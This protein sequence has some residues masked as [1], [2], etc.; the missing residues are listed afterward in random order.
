MADK[1]GTLRDRRT[2]VT[3]ASGNY[4]ILAD[5]SDSLAY[6]R[7]GT[8][9]VVSGFNGEP[10]EYPRRR[11]AGRRRR[12]AARADRSRDAAFQATPL[13]AWCVQGSYEAHELL[14]L[15][16]RSL[17]RRCRRRVRAGKPLGGTRADRT[18]GEAPTI[19]A[20][21]GGR[22]RRS[23][24]L[25]DQRRIHGRP[26]PRRSPGNRRDQYAH[27]LP[28]GMPVPEEQVLA[29]LPTDRP[30]FEIPCATPSPADRRIGTLVA[31]RMGR[32]FDPADRD[33]Q[34]PRHG[35]R[36]AAG[37]ARPADPHRDAVRRPGGARAIRGRSRI[38]ERSGTRVFAF[39][40]D[41]LYEFM[42]GNASLRMGPF[43]EVN[44]PA[45][46]A[47]E[48]NMV[49]VCATTEVDLYGQCVSGTITDDWYSGSGGQLDFMRGVHAAPDGQ[50]FMLLH[51][52]LSDGSS[53]I[54]LS[55][56]PSSAVTTGPTW[57]TKS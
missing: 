42:D 17:V 36:G 41:I 57:S 46:I 18:P 4:K 34:R 28:A 3:S 12:P 15:S 40:T 11:R 35:L 24:L 38:A 30:M 13:D 43:D 56:S 31:E 23:P 44:D 33:R 6:I 25:G 52:T 55:L 19:G 53:R 49:A 8:D 14:P 9:L 48:P 20:R 37:H 39:G 2:A 32:R 47:R 1:L 27:A 16:G 10:V 7:D 26:H 54:K 22:A 45:S 51:A 21:G 50:G 29:A 5:A